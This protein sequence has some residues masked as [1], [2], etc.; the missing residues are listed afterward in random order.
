MTKLLYSFH[1]QANIQQN[2][3][4]SYTSENWGASQADKY[5]DGLHSHLQNI[6]ENLSL[7]RNVPEYI[8]PG[9]KFFHYGR[10]FVFVREAGKYRDEK[11]QVLSILHDRMDIPSRLLEELK[12]L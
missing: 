5:I 9:I 4:W 10:H 11:I 1:P 6:S 12:K 2:N 8:I 3:I 7:L